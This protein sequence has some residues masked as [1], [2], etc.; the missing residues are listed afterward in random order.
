M[1]LEGLLLGDDLILIYFLKHPVEVRCSLRSLS[2]SLA[3]SLP[4]EKFGGNNVYML[5]YF[6]PA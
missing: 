2:S 5:F 6:F 1:W 3:P 4:E